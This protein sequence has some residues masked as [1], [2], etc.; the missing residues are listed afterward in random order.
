MVSQV[1][2]EI[3]AANFLFVQTKN[4]NKVL[5]PEKKTNYNCA[6]FVVLYDEN[7]G[8][9]LVDFRVAAK[10]KNSIVKIDTLVKLIV[11]IKTS[12]LIKAI[13]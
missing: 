5:S 11:N 13:T 6:E 2:N 7:N 3:K 8:L 9:I 1:K 12:R 4:N 10:K